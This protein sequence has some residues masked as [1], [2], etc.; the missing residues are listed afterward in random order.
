[1]SIESIIA[2]GSAVGIGVAAAVITLS[3]LFGRKDQSRDLQD[4]DL[5]IAIKWTLQALQ[6]TQSRQ[7]AAT[8]ALHT[9]Y[10]KQ[11]KDLESIHNRLD[12]QVTIIESLHKQL[13]AQL[14]EIKRNA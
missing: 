4:H 12:N 14:A 2:I 6:E 1:M 13:S 3:K 9:R 8:K 7:L 5:L 11:V 10:D